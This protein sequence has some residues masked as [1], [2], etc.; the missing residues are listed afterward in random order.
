VSAAGLCH[1]DVCIYFTFSHLSLHRHVKKERDDFP[2]F[3]LP[4]CLSVLLQLHILHGAYPIPKKFTLSH[5]IAGV[6][7]QLGFGVDPAKVVVGKLYAV[8]SMVPCTHCVMCTSGRESVC[9][10]RRAY[11]GVGRDGGFAPFVTV[12]VTALVEVPAGVHLQYVFSFSV[13]IFIFIFIFEFYLIIICYFCSIF[14][15]LLL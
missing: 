12:P 11:L 15:F 7:T 4:L 6:A 1:S 13:L 14:N 10:S 2:P 9:L 8:L 5:E 3:L